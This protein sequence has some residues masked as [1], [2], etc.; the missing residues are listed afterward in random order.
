M[1][2]THV[3]LRNEILYLVVQNGLVRKIS[4]SCGP[5]DCSLPGSSIHGNSQVRI[6]E[7]VVISFSRGSSQLFIPGIQL[8]YIFLFF[9]FSSSYNR[10]YFLDGKTKMTREFYLEVCFEWHLCVTEKTELMNVVAKP[11]GIMSS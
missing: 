4:D 3:N 9:E 11:Q 2:Y 1:L 6:L 7:W 5:M 8:N 10:E